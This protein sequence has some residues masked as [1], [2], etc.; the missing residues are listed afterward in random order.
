MTD[1][2]DMS[3]QLMRLE[4]LLAAKLGIRGTGLDR[5]LRKAAPRLPRGL[6]RDGRVVAEAARL[7]QHPK[8]ARQIDATR[9]ERAYERLSSHLSGID[10]ADRRKGLALSVLAGLAFNLLL[11]GGLIMAFAAWRGWL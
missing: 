9:F 1:K 2:G 3:Q 7:S 6:R 11:L 10:V 8:L 4:G 5:G